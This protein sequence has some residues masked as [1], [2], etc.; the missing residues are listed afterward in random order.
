MP[1]RETDDYIWKVPV[2][3][4]ASLGESILFPELNRSLLFDKYT[5]RPFDR[6]G[7]LLFE[8]R[9][10]KSIPIKAHNLK[11]ILN[12][13]YSISKNEYQFLKNR[14]NSADKIKK[15]YLTTATRLLINHGG[16][17]VLESNIALHPFY[18]FPIIYGSA[19]K[20]VTRLYCGSEVANIDNDTIIKIFGN[21]PEKEPAQE[22]GIVF[23]DAWPA[24]YKYLDSLEL[25]VITPH[26]KDY[27]EKKDFPQDTLQPSPHLFLAVKKDTVFEFAIYPAKSDNK[28]NDKLLEKTEGLIKQALKEYGIGAKTGSNYGY[29]KE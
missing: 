5:F 18:G 1:R 7:N 6:R 8:D 14:K 22:G 16:E 29:F 23:C 27:Y 21:E 3:W 15:F 10:N 2:N 11:N 25:D 24:E 9:G 28:D 19:I 13:S 17:S 4:L 20:G 26:Y 12:V